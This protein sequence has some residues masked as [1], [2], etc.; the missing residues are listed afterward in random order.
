MWSARRMRWTLWVVALLACPVPYGGLEQ[1]W[2]PPLWLGT[3]AL[4]AGGV[5]AIEGGTTPLQIAAVFAI[6]ALLAAGVLWLASW[7]VVRLAEWALGEAEAYRV[8]RGVLV[9]LI[10]LTVCPVY[11]API[12]HAAGWATL[13]GLWR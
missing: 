2:V 8:V 3:M 12:S 6:Q 13:A 11:R 9:V 4:L 1:G 5:A 10:A 7:L